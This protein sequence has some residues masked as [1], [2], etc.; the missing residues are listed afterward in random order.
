MLIARNAF[1]LVTLALS[2]F[3]AGGC[4]AAPVEF[5]V[6]GDLPYGKDQVRSLELIGKN[7]RK[8]GFPFVITLPA[9]P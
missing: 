1:G 3:L 2:L 5:V 4:L 8:S 6:L 9:Y 7:I